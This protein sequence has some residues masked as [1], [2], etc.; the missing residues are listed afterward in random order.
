MK[1]KKLTISRLRMANCVSRLVDFRPEPGVSTTSLAPLIFG[2]GGYTRCPT[3][4]GGWP[5]IDVVLTGV[6]GLV[7]PS[8]RLK[9]LRLFGSGG[10]PCS[11]DIVFILENETIN[12]WGSYQQMRY[13][14]EGTTILLNKHRNQRTPAICNFIISRNGSFIILS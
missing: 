5:R 14:H 6:G 1:N 4:E 7:W 9:P 11:E 8:R 12:K 2:C 3:F 13:R 10:R